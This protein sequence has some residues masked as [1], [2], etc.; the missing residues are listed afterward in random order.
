MLT[1]QSYDNNLHEI[2]TSN[3]TKSTCIGI[4]YLFRS[5]RIL[6][7]VFIISAGQLT[8]QET[9]LYS[10]NNK[11]IE[12]GENHV[13]SKRLIE[14]I[15]GEMGDF[16]DEDDGDNIN[17]TRNIP[18]DIQDFENIEKVARLKTWSF[19]DNPDPAINFP[20]QGTPVFAGDVNND[21]TNDYLYFSKQ[22]RDER[23]DDLSDNTGKT[24]LYFGGTPGK[25]PD[26]LLYSGLQPAGNLNGDDYDDAVEVNPEEETIR[27]FTGAENGYEEV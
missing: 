9:S 24:A 2:S 27:F 25:E 11:G 23:T 21:G 14:Q 12:Y 22:A 26:Q 19:A 5:I 7:L 18:D 20:I 3:N 4:G 8:A 17:G 6:I 10:G 15:Q 1:T 16:Q 13:T